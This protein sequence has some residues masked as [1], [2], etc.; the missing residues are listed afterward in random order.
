MLEYFTYKRIE[1]FTAQSLPSK[2]LS[3]ALI[4]FIVLF[5]KNGH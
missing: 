5:S 4:L 1:E 2:S 3:T